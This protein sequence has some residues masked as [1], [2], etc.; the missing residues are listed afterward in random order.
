MPA[1]MISRIR[2]NL[3][4]LNY[5][6][7]RL[8]FVHFWKMD[9]KKGTRISLSAKLDKTHPSGV[10]I[11]KNTAVAFG[12]AILA[13]DFINGK[14]KDVFIGENCLIG[15][16]SVIM[17]GVQ[18]GNNCIVSPNSVVFQNVPAGSI[19]MGNPAKI[20]QWNVI[21]GPWGTRGST[22]ESSRERSAAVQA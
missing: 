18:I 13:H 21:T 2:S 1:P 11:G 4:L 12:S 19:V 17:P 6:L 20:V 3:A 15:A 7:R 5:E 14:Y 16:G 8:Y 22:Q 9:I 10:H